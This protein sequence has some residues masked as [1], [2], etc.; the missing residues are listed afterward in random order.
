M[1][2]V[3]ILQNVT[4]GVRVALEVA[5]GADLTDLTGASWTWTD[6]TT[7]IDVSQNGITIAPDELNRAIQ[8]RARCRT[9]REPLLLQIGRRQ[10]DGGEKIAIRRVHLYNQ[11]DEI[12]LRGVM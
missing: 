3:A 2:G 12:G 10:I 9:Q 7:D 4:S 5:W 1:T 6:I 11:R 8:Q